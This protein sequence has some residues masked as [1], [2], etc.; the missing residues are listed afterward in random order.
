M[1]EPTTAMAEMA[2]VSDISGVCSSRDTRR[3][4]TPSP[5]NVASTSTVSEL[6]FASVAG[7]NVVDAVAAVDT[8]HEQSSVQ[9][10]TKG[11]GNATRL[12]LP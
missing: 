10:I 11:A 6:Q 5:I 9:Q 3:P 7:S 4:I 2:L 12:R 1:I 8:K